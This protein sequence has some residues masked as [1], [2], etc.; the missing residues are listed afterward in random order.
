MKGIYEAL[1]AAG[2][3]NR[4]DAE[5]LTEKQGRLLITVMC[6]SLKGYVDI[7]KL[8]DAEN[9]DVETDAGRERLS[10]ASD[11]AYS[12]ND[13]ERDIRQLAEHIIRFREICQTV[14]KVFGGKEEGADD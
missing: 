1:A 5:K 10:Y 14:K 3:V 6:E 8:L 7:Y 13:V 12:A 2:I 4:K 11:V 9:A